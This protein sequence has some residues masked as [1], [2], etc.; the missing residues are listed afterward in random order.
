MKINTGLTGSEEGQFNTLAQRE[1]I[2]KKNKLAIVKGNGADISIDGK[3]KGWAK[4]KTI[5]QKI[6]LCCIDVAKK[7][8]AEERVKQYWNTYYCLNRVVSS[9][10]R[11]HGKYCKNRFCTLC[12]CIRKAK[13]INV[14]FQIMKNWKQ[15]YFVTL[16]MKAV[17][18][19]R[20]NVV[21]DKLIEGFQRIKNNQRKRSLRGTGNAL[22]GVRSLE[23]N[24]NPEKG[25]YN[26]HLHLIVPNEEMAEFLVAEWLRI[27]TPKW[28]KRQ[29]Q[30]IRQIE[31]MER[32]LIECVKYGTKV[33]TEPEVNRSKKK[34]GRS[35]KIFVSALDNISA[36]MSDHRLFERFG[37]NTLPLTQKRDTKITAVIEFDE[38]A[39]IAEHSDWFSPDLEA[40]LSGYEMPRQLK[41]LLGENVDLLL[42]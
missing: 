21:I 8:G 32:D 33:F 36:A 23:C 2:S 26:P 41:I 37:F 22:M 38:W 40:G 20:L 6:V 19:D 10:G 42:Q 7:K 34:G 14:Y 29:A 11:L 5:T 3:M 4:R 15:A 30:N 18:S 16:T 31:N 13:I 35:P 27:W 39:F 17:K 12:L 25:T 28:A 1:T 9:N 24:F